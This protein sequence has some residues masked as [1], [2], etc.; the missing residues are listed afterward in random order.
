MV[1]A[2]RYNFSPDAAPYV[3][4]PVLQSLDGLSGSDSTH[5]TP[6]QVQGSP[7]LSTP[8]CNPS[9][10]P[11]L[12]A[13]QGLM[14]PGR[15]DDKGGMPIHQMLNLRTSPSE[16]HF[17]VDVPS[18]VLSS[19]SSSWLSDACRPLTKYSSE[20][21]E[22]SSEPGTEPLP[23]PPRTSLSFMKAMNKDRKMRKN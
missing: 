21:E 20:S 14:L 8:G 2:R 15:V 12:P 11:F 13:S 22:A 19:C 17:P 3:P 16:V 4:S 9:A 7:C 6:K 23:P 1:N 18:E 5:S 10:K